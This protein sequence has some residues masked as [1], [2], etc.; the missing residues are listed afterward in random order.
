MKWYIVSILFISYCLVF[1]EYF[2]NSTIHY[3][4]MISFIG[5]GIF[6]ILISVELSI[7]RK[8]KK[9]GNVKEIELDIFQIG[10]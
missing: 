7:L 9:L 5:R 2:G 6:S 3:Y 1:P 4:E 8:A 10:T